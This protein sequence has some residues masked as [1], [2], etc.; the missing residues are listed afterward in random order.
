ML[1]HIITCLWVFADQIVSA[2]SPC[3]LDLGDYESMGTGDMYLVSLYFTVTTITT[4]GYGDISAT[5]HVE[6]WF[7]IF[8]MLCGVI[9]FSFATGTLSS[10]MSGYDDQ[11]ANY[12][13]KLNMLEKLKKQHDLP[14]VLYGRVKHTLEIT[15]KNELE[16][17]HDFIS[18]LPQKLRNEMS[19]HIY[20][21]MYCKIS[22]L[23]D[24][25]SP[26]L[27][28]IFPLLEPYVLQEDMY[29]YYENDDA[30][31]IYFHH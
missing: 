16:G 19:N 31:D 20:K 26:F 5:N 22:F 8:I 29:L 12:I 18:K 3:W 11:N 14:K 28:W 24:K 4:V 15:E 27:S 2:D 13:E 17:I 10:I 9:A 21:R 30:S 25:Q 23:Q 6:R 7:C 1:C